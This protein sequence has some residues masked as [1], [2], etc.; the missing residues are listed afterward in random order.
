MFS[1]GAADLQ[2]VDVTDAA[3][4]RLAGTW[5]SPAG[6]LHS[7]SL[8]ADGHRAYLSLWTGG[9]LVADATQFTTGQPN[10]QLTGAGER[11][12]PLPGG[13]AHSAV[14]VPG[15]DLLV[16]TDERYPPACPYGPARV[17][18]VSDPAHPRSVAVMAAP[19]NDLATCRASPSGTYTSH[20]P[21]IVQDLALV[22]WYSSGLQV[23]DL[24]DPAHPRRLAE[25]R[26]QGSEPG[27]RSPELGAALTMT[28]SY[29]VVRDGLVYVADINQGLYVFRYHG[30][31]EEELS[32]VA[33]AEGNSNL[34]VLRPPPATVQPATAP[35][36]APAA[37]PIRPAPRRAAA[38]AGGLPPVLAGVVLALLLAGAVLAG[39]VLFRML[40]ARRRGP[41][42]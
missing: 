17:A 15:R 14:A 42:R 10:P 41:V 22:T 26:P 9:L 28:W 38:A 30:P 21:T 1:G 12:G 5:A 16:L 31:H 8:S 36:A 23:F 32:R 27:Q 4:P 24:S 19:E 6:V 35:T 40:L 18:D 7:I 3:A 29:P 25:A 11:L 34:F 39:L 37:G 2:V 33:F 20:N 13:N